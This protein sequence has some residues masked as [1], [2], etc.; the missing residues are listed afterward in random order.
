MTPFREKVFTP[1][2]NLTSNFESHKAPSKAH[3]FAGAE[4]ETAPAG[5]NGGPEA[6]P[7]SEQGCCI[8]L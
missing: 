2:G 6:E 7:P 4:G 3:I 1:I 8:L 5:N